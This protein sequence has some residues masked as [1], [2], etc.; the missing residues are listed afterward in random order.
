MGI[1]L[2]SKEMTCRQ[3]ERK[4]NELHALV[5]S[6]LGRR[7]C[8]KRELQS[9]VGKIQHACKVVRPGRTFLRRVFELLRV[10][11]KPHHHIRLTGAVK[12]DIYWWHTFLTEWN[13]VSLL[14]AESQAAP[15]YHCFRCLGTLWLWGAVERAMAGTR[16]GAR[17]CGGL[18]SS[19][20]TYPNCDG[21]CGM[22]WGV[23]AGGGLLRL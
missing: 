14:Q 20:R 21:L 17:V 12:L 6:W 2:D 16:M 23:A 13:G 15:D 8:T 7:S 11:T 18:Y 10:A 9:L 22:G 19:Q 1:V 4:L 5:G 3:P